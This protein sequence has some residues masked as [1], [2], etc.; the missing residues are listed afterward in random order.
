[1]G[2]LLFLLL[3]LLLTK[4][5]KEEHRNQKTSLLA[6][7]TRIYTAG[8]KRSNRFEPIIS[9]FDLEAGLVSDDGEEKLPTA[10]LRVPYDTLSFKAHFFS[11]RSSYF[12]ILALRVRIHHAHSIKRAALNATSRMRRRTTAFTASIIPSHFNRASSFVRS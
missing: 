5:K 8:I 2:R 1:M 11:H 12:F 9:F 6:L 3:S 10:S 4:V 7:E